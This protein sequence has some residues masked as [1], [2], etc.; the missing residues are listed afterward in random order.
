[1]TAIWR[2][3]MD[4]DTSVE[5][6][7]SPRTLSLVTHPVVSFGPFRLIP[8]QRLLLEGDKP[9][10]LGS[11]ALDILIA[12]LDRPGEL[13]SKEEIMARVWPNT[14]VEGANLTVHVAALRR[15]LSDGQAG[16][17]FVINIPGRGYRFVAPINLVHDPIANATPVLA[18][19]HAHNLP[20]GATR[21]IGR[22][23]TVK[24][25]TAQLYANRLLT[26][27]GPAGI[28]KTA[29]ALAVA[30]EQIPN[31]EHGVWLIDLAPLGEPSMV[32]SELAS[33]LGIEVRSDNPLPTVIAMLREKQML[34]LLDNCEHVVG[35]AAALTAGVL[36]G[37][38]RLRILATSRE[39]LR[40]EGEHVHRLMPL[41]SPPIGT[42]LSAD[43]A[44]KFPAAQLFVERAGATMNEF[45][46]D[47]AE[48][49]IVVEI[50]RKLDGIP[51][52][53]ELAA[54][55]VEAFGVQ[56][57][58]DRLDD[59]MR[60]LTSGRRTA[61]PRHHTMSA[62]L[63]WSFGLLDEAEQKIMR[64]IA[65]FAGSFTLRA[66]GMVTADATHPE[67]EIVEIVTALVAKSLISV[68]FA[69]TEPRLRLLETTRAYALSKLAES[70]ESE[71]LSRRHAEYY[72]DLLES[73]CPSEDFLIPEN[74]L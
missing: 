27:I 6:G 45:E 28:G 23:D 37:A 13:V 72:R 29:V 49:G 43:E 59:R 56:G 17:R 61:L 2:L 26:I 30:E 70:G 8:A 51:L 74:H 47:G 34:L 16:N 50:C 12:L 55:R 58:A 44:L 54:A 62:A 65:I 57:L 46:P 14:F 3:P 4:N 42:R 22:A 52:A 69:E 5:S 71:M 25:L 73:Q 32:P 41:E 38:P 11:R 21:L 33:A 20:A 67:S 48:A 60:L 24:T 7:L 18:A 39:P 53:I 40:T 19:K 31:Y 63:D 10:R 66:A 15:A 35:A 9:V 36:R 64:R 1:M 68:D